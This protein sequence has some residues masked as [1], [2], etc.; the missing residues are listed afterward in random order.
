MPKHVVVH[1]IVIK[2]TSCDTVVFDYIPFSK[3]HTQNGDDTLPRLNFLDIFSRNTQILN[4][5]NIRP[6][7]AELFH[8]EGWTDRQTDMTNLIGAILLC[9]SK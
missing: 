8:V 9:S 2:Y 7:E 5:I 4:F 3:F 6:A 1:H